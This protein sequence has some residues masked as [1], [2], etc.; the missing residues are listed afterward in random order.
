MVFVLKMTGMI[1]EPASKLPIFSLKPFRAAE[2]CQWVFQDECLHRI[3]ESGLPPK[4]KA[5]KSRRTSR[6]TCQR[7]FTYS[8]SLR[9]ERDRNYSERVGIR[10]ESLLSSD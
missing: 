6:S 2:A 5:L 1:P 8:V 7:P 4:C 9:T 3:V 10:S